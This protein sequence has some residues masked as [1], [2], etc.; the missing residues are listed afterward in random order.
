MINKKE[1]TPEQIKK[2][3]VKLFYKNVK[4]KKSDS[5]ASNTKLVLGIDF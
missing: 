2:R 4:G 5:S 3:I 1:E